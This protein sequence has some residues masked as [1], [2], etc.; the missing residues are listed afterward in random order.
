MKIKNQKKLIITISVV[1][2]LLLVVFLQGRITGFAV[3]DLY[4]F[5]IQPIVDSPPD[6]EEGST[7]EEPI[8]NSSKEFNKEVNLEY[9]EVKE[10]KKEFTTISYNIEIFANGGEY[11]CSGNQPYSKCIKHDGKEAYY[12]ELVEGV[13]Q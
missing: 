13:S 3:L 9:I 10:Q 12:G 8:E 6:I 5:G 11:R 2:L 4:D 1:I 7:N